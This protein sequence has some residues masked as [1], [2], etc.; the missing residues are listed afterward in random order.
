MEEGGH[1]DPDIRIL[2]FNSAMVPRAW[3]VPF[4]WVNMTPLGRPVVPLV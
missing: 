2:R 1:V 3:R 4:L